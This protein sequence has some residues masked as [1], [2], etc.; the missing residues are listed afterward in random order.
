MKLKI[1][2][3]FIVFC[4]SPICSQTYEKDWEDLNKKLNAQ[5]KLEV[6]AFEAFEN[7]HQKEIEQYPDNSMKFYSFYAYALWNSKDLKNAEESFKWSYH[8]ATKASDTT[9]KYIAI[10]RFGEFFKGIGNYAEAEKYYY[11]CMRPLSVILGASSREYSEIY[12]EYTNVLM[13]L[14]KF[15]EAKPA[16]EGLL[17]YYKTMDGE[18]SRHYIILLNWLFSIHKFQG[19]YDKAIELSSKIVNDSL[20]LLISDTSG[21]IDSYD[22]LGDIYRETS[23]YDQA[24]QYFKKG[25]QEFFRLKANDRHALA[26]LENNMGLCFKAFGNIKEAEDAF[27]SALNIY[28]ETNETNTEDYCIALN[29]KGDLFRELGRVGLA[30]EI[31]LGSLEIRKKYLGTNSKSYANTLN[32]LGLVYFDAGLYEE[33]LKRTLEAKEVYEITVGKEHQFYGN[34][35]NNLSLLYLKLNDFKKAESYK[36]QAL[37]I[38]EKSVGKNHFR[39]SS[40]LISTYSLYLRTNQLTK[41]EINLREALLLVDKN[42]GRKHDLY[43]R[44]QLGLAE[45]NARIGKFELASPL[46]FESLEYY[47][48]QLNNYFDAMSEENQALYFNFIEPAFESYNVFLINYKL[49]Q[50]TKDLSAHIKRALQNQ[51][52]LKSLLGKKSAKLQQQV[53]GSKNQEY[54]NLFKEWVIAKNILINNSKSTDRVNDDN[55]LIRK[56]SGIEATLKSKF[57]SFSKSE[58][59]TFDQLKES[60]GDKEAA[61]EIF[62]AY[63][64]INDSAHTI[65]YGAIVIKKN[66]LNPELHIFNNGKGM[67]EK[68]FN[69]Y[70]NAID[71][72]LPDTLSYAIFFKDLKKYLK[73]INKLFISPDGVF[74]TINLASLFDPGAKKYV[75]EEFEIYNTANVSSL[76][77]KSNKSVNNKPQAALFGYPDYE[78]DFKKRSTSANESENDAVAKRY[79]LNNLSKLPGTK[80]EVEEISKEL[81]AKA[82]NV[83]VYTEE[84]ASEENLRN[85]KSPNVLHIATHGYYLK[86]VETEDKLFLGF[87]S[88][89]LKSNSFLRSGIILAGVGP[90]TRDSLNINSEND[91]IFSAYEASL[92]NLS[93]TELVVLSACQTGLGDNMGSQGVAGLQRSF[94]IAGAKNIIMSLWP[95]DDDAT[96]MLM[97]EF[98]KNYAITLNI[99][100]AFR[101]AQTLVKERYKHPYYWAAFILLKTFN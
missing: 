26:S 81:T 10:Y 98:Y 38:I 23:R 60:L 79:G 48:N 15:T 22:N 40:F 66:S 67:E 13:N 87:E 78:Y 58:I 1:I 14:G 54:I 41:A 97:A 83:T 76:V 101:Q 7:K 32:N 36:L 5:T 90:S 9:L 84:L 86:D 19:E 61:I 99:E 65:K 35:L 91:G 70:L 43:A 53:Y 46:Y 85:I 59:V 68:N 20:F 96:K 80:K 50:P 39:Y 25:K 55:E 69:N 11:T 12:F 28:K 62:K 2:F 74:Q 16:V 3:L 6:K 100:S 49:S 18:K 89:T 17:Y 93:T 57:S 45:I 21:Y 63:E 47:S 37:A 88:K 4:Y 30:S 56:V 33:A 51:M 71:N 77:N 24:F 34:C 8:Y 52:L 82:W 29:N 75:Q 31:L 72:Q 64:W 94:A 27:N 73:E 44:A 92:L 42:L 95:V